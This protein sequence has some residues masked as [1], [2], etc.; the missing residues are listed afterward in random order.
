MKRHLRIGLVVLLVVLVVGGIGLVLRPGQASYEGKS[1]HAWLRAEEQMKIISSWDHATM[2]VSF[3]ST[4]PV[5]RAFREMGAAAVPTLIQELNARDSTLKTKL[6][7]WTRSWS[8]ITLTSAN[9]RHQRAVRA[10]AV[11]GP[12]A[13]N[14]LP[15]LTKLLNERP[16]DPMLPRT[17]AIV[18]PEARPAILMAL[19]NADPEVRWTMASALPFVSYDPG[20]AI[21]ALVKCL[22]EVEEKNVRCSATVALGQIGGM[23]DLVIPALTQNLS[24]KD[25][26][27]RGFSVD[28]LAQIQSRL[29]TNAVANE[30]EQTNAK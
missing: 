24:D 6:M 15:A 10:C 26:T 4:N 21:P 16:V 30:V 25:S 28:A 13:T 5:V 22:S 9:V 27:V 1:V 7:K 8:W 19:T 12:L 14:A 2:T 29:R 20:F 23:P 3:R 11:L 17:L 18:G